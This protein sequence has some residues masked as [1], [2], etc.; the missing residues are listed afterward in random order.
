MTPSRPDGRGGSKVRAISLSLMAVL[1]VVVAL[2]VFWYRS[3]RLRYHSEIR[4][5]EA[6]I[7]K[8][9]DFKN[10]TGHLPSEAEVLDKQ[11]ILFFRPLKSGYQV[12]FNLG[13]DDY[14][15][16]DSKARRWSFERP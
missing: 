13:F 15:S 5:T 2:V 4:A 11:G 9:E 6:L 7:A 12:G 8:I 10:K 3:P 1:V 16:Y 14:A